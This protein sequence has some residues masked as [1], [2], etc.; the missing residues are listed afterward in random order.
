M[1]KKLF[2]IP[3]ALFGILLGCNKKGPNSEVDK[4]YINV[5]FETCIDLET[6]VIEDQHLQVGDKVDEPAV[7]V[8]GDDSYDHRFC[9]SR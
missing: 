2:I 1:N 6:N 7:V 8:L 5:H 3:L 9:P 4:D